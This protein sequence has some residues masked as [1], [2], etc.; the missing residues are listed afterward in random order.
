MLSD[1]SKKNVSIERVAKKAL[2][3]KKALSELLKGILSL[4][5]AGVEPLPQHKA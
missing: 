1:L 5:G 3:D 4:G 2:K